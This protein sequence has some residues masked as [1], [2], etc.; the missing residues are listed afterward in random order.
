[1]N[2]GM[3]WFCDK[4]QSFPKNV[5]NAVAYYTKKYGT[6]P[7]LVLCN[8]NDLPK[9]SECIV[10]VRPYHATLPGHLWVGKEENS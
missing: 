1:M 2:T 8:P 6:T 7:D 3:L 10:T 5:E 4:K 9:D